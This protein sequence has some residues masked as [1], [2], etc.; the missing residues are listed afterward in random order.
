M[1]IT[2]KPHF[3][4]AGSRKAIPKTYSHSGAIG[5][6]WSPDP[7]ITYRS[8]DQVTKHVY[9]DCSRNPYPIYPP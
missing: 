3:K 6:G 7:S 9:T 2:D 1:G 5:K 4:E 8:G